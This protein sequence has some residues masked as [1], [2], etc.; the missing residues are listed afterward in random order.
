LKLTGLFIWLVLL[1]SACP[2]LWCQNLVVNGGF[3]TGNFSGWTGSFGTVVS[4]GAPEGSYYARSPGVGSGSIYQDLATTVGTVY[5][6][7]Y[8]VRTQLVASFSAQFGNPAALTTL[9]TAGASSFTLRSFTFQ[10]TTATSRIQF[11][12]GTFFGR[13]SLDDVLVRSTVPEL[14]ASRGALP[15]V[16]LGLMFLVL[17][18]RTLRHQVPTGVGLLE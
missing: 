13:T 1:V 4:G 6:I 16:L 18:D 14:D 2:P 9:D 8:R 11:S 10:A 7:S 3:E 5:R 17:Y 12:Y 15:L